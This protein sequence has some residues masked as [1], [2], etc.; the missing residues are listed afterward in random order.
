[1]LSALRN[2]TW[3][4]AH[5]SIYSISV[6]IYIYIYIYSVHVLQDFEG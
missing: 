3:F 1:M 6:Y 5:V 2:F 4:V